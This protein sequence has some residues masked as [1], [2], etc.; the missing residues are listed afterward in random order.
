[1][2]PRQAAHQDLS[3]ILAQLA[4]RSRRA[5]R[6]FLEEQLVRALE[7]AHA[8]EERALSFDDTIEGYEE[9]DAATLRELGQIRAECRE[10][11]VQIR[12]QVVSM[13]EHFRGLEDACRA[14]LPLTTFKLVGEPFPRPPADDDTMPELPTQAR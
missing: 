14:V 4:G 10:R 11:M 9:R 2:T 3:A 1:M 6:A 5:Q 8:A 7:R 13:A 12:C